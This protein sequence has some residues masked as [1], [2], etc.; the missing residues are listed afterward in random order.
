MESIHY[1]ANEQNIIFFLFLPAL[2]RYD[3]QMTFCKFKVCDLMIWC[4]YMLQNDR[5]RRLI[6]TPI[7][8]ENHSFSLCG[9]DFKDLPCKF[10]V[11]DTLLVIIVTILC[12][13]FQN[14]VDIE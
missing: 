6:N 2:L 1:P 3:Q 13:R 8:S 14:E 7:I 10:Q 11:Y 5:Y 4:T 12:I 9:D